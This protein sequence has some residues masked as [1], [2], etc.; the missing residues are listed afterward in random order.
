V[1]VGF[2]KLVKAGPGFVQRLTS[3][4]HVFVLKI[5]A[6]FKLDLTAADQLAAAWSAA[7]RTKFN[8]S[9]LI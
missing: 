4:L 7:K 9:A 6:F 1:L 5:G 2:D 3:P 8:H